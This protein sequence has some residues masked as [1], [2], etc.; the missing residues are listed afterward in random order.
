MCHPQAGKTE[1][2][3]TLDGRRYL[4]HPT[5]M[6]THTQQRDR[7][8][9]MTSEMFQFIHPFQQTADYNEY[10]MD[11]QALRGGFWW[12]PDLTSTLVPPSGHMFHLYSRNLMDGLLSN[13]LTSYILFGNSVSWLQLTVVNDPN[14][15]FLHVSKRLLMMHLA[16]S[17]LRQ[18]CIQSRKQ[19]CAQNPQR[20][21]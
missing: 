7:S 2:W 20:D 6:H 1:Q 10:V 13:L 4:L 17:E 14:T 19:K 15:N 18:Y 9:G 12:P 16:V 8:V 21:T 11:I 3:W 5:H